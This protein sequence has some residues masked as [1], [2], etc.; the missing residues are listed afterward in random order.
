M[1]VQ[2]DPPTPT[3]T[4]DGH[5]HPPSALNE[6]PS[7]NVDPPPSTSEEP[8]HGVHDVT[9]IIPTP[10]VDNSGM[11]L[12]PWKKKTMT[13]LLIGETG[14]GKTAF[15]DLLAN[16]CAGRKLEDFTPAH[17]V[18]NEAG[19]SVT[20]SQTN[21]PK[22]YAVQ[23]ANG[24]EVR[25]LDTPGLADTRGIEYDN[26]HKAAIAEAIKDKVATI[27]SIVI[28]A[29]GT[30]ERLGVATDYALNI[31]SGM[32]PNSIVD[33]IAFIFT[34]VSNPL[35]FNFKRNALH[36]SLRN[37]KLWTMDNPFAGWLKYQSNVH[38]DYP[39]DE[40]ILEE[41]YQAT[42]SSY[43]KTLKTLNLLFRWQSERQV[44]PTKE[45]DRLYQMSQDIDASINNI[46]A[47]LDQQEDEMSNLVKVKREI[48]AQQQVSTVRVLIQKLNE[49]FRT[50]MKKPFFEHE[51]TDKHNTLCLVG[52]C[53]SNCHIGCG[54]PFTLDR[55]VI[56]AFCIAFDRRRIFKDDG[57]HVCRVCGHS[58]ALH[59]HYKS[60]W[61]KK[62][63]IETMEDSEA[64]ARYEMATSEVGRAAILRKQIDERIISLRAAMVADKDTLG[65]LCF[66]YSKLALSGSFSGHIM[67]TIRV[68][69]MRYEKLK[70]EGCIDPQALDQMSEWMASLRQKQKIVD[71]AARRNV[72][73][74]GLI[75]NFASAIGISF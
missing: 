47:R 36:P 66:T 14:V 35:Q 70:K 52:N 38:A 75:I 29:N 26:K 31:I 25:I 68:L 10:E 67:H 50:V 39:P 72:E 7:N 17:I 46:Q 11:T 49:E 19:G 18:D 16:I 43:M 53:Y 37:A 32:F 56:G 71:E 24:H 33:N 21:E 2:V 13:I 51:P 8:L 12:K 6:T 27:D 74:V 59:Q 3:N 9:A 41:M 4:P 42:R 30:Q 48:E 34:M 61:T 20:G 73:K 58:S 44:Q 60:R 65:R 28:L 63:K 57:G 23:C 15:L 55:S 1:T 45:I 64:K 22:L 54:V 69:R 5:A 40:E 62:E